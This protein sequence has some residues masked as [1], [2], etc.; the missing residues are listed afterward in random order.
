MD[1]LRGWTAI[2]TLYEVKGFQLAS[3]YFGPLY[4]LL[5]TVVFGFGIART[6]FKM[7]ETNRARDLVV[8]VSV[9][10]LL[11][12]LI[13]PTTV[14]VAAPAGYTYDNGLGEMVESARTGE[15]TRATVSGVPRIMAFAHVAIDHLTRFVIQRVDG[16]FEKNPFGHD[17]AATL[18][19]FS[20]IKDES[21]RSQYHAFVAACYVRV[22]AERERVGKPAPEPYYD[23][24]KLSLDEYNPF[25]M[26]DVYAPTYASAPGGYV[27][28]NPSVIPGEPCGELARTLYGRL[29]DDVDRNHGETAQAVHDVLQAKGGYGVRPGQVQHAV[30][31]DVVIRYILHNE[32]RGLLATSEIVALQKALSDDTWSG[33]TR[34]V[35]NPQ[36]AV[37]H[38]ASVISSLVQLKSNID[39][40]INLQAEGPA[41]YFKAVSYGP[42]VYGIAGMLILALFPLAA[43]IALLP[44]HWTALFTWMKY[45]LSVKLWMVFWSILSRFNEYR[46]NL[47]DLGDGPEN[48]VGN[49][50][51]MFPALAAMYLLTPGLS[52]IAVQLL[53]SAGKASAGALGNLL[54]GGGGAHGGDVFASAAKAVHVAGM[55]GRAAGAAA[56]PAGIAAA[57][58]AEAAA[59]ESASPSLGGAEARGAGVDW[60]GAPPEPRRQDAAEPSSV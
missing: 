22:L 23:P 55:V 19:R 30:V 45:L 4:L 51:Y 38:V 25:R 26:P 31:S 8:Y 40:A 1:E 10:V 42:Y 33:R 53:S 11:M 3:A 21:L 57:G 7:T 44:G 34:G 14:A 20:R 59:S 18:L 28:G 52:F 12:W 35:S 13:Q 6:L 46:Y 47:E 15:G 49:A 2:D 27:P 60:A 32:T 39:S 56:G 36:N 48:G 54:G 50:A 37:D 9:A 17:R 24:F 58:A 43:F 5:V 41:T 29:K 16:S